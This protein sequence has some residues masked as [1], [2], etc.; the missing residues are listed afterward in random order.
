M[1]VLT[2]IAIPFNFFFE[3]S[4]LF[5]RKSLDS[6]STFCLAK[7]I[8]LSKTCIHVICRQRTRERTTTFWMFLFIKIWLNKQN[9]R[10]WLDFR[11][12]LIHFFFHFGFYFYFDGFKFNNNKIGIGRKAP[13][14]DL[15]E[16]FIVRICK[17]YIYI[18]LGICILI[19]LFFLVFEH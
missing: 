11:K 19:L 15:T 1:D 6:P 2:Q 7:H 8:F 9:T 14:R 13:T 17:V 4:I 5:R 3:V 18:F 16:L 10:R 12:Y